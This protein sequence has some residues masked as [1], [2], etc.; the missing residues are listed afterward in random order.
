MLLA[1]G[2]IIYFNTKDNAVPYFNSIGKECPPLTTPSDYFM[3]IMSIEHIEKEDVDPE[4]KEKMESSSILVQNTYKEL[5][6][7]FDKSY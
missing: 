2:K 5:I 3:S 1:K 7:M 6:D 4:D